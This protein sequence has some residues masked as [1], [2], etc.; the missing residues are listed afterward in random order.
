MPMTI[1]ILMK[2]LEVKAKGNPSQMDGKIVIN[3]IQMLEKI[4]I[5]LILPEK[6]QQLSTQ[7]YI[8]NNI[9]RETP[10]RDKNSKTIYPR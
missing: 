6:T 5:P 3:Y 2:K 1:Q 7:V 9:V 8:F 4:R 10:G